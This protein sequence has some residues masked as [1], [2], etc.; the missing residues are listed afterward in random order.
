M[1]YRVLAPAFR[2]L[3][4]IED[5]VALRFGEAVALNTSRKL[6][7]AFETLATHP[8]MGRLRPEVT[9]LPLRFYFAAPNWIVYRPGDPVVIHRVFD[10]RMDATA[11]RLG[12]DPWDQL[13]GWPSHT[14]PIRR[15][16]PRD[17]WDDHAAD[18]RS[19]F[20]RVSSA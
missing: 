17:Q 10:A 20:S 2:D 16:Y 8:E 14:C 15:R 4:R 19:L 18:R 11:I 12:S 6:T 7:S 1:T 9:T 13:G 3:N 5:W